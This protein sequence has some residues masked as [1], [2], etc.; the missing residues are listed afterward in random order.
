MLFG[1]TALEVAIGMIFVYLLLSLLCSAVAEYIE[2]WRGVRGKN[3]RKGIEMLLND[4][5]PKG[6]KLAAGKDLAARLYSHGLI[7]PLYRERGKLPSYIPSRTF[8][9]A[10]WDM[11]FP[12][13]QR[14]E[15]AGGQRA[16]SGR[17]DHRVPLSERPVN[18]C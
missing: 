9:L 2:A 14:A 12:A 15:A 6:E 7:R 10:L 13:E 16:G 18:L 1:S 17:R 4:L 3:L 8:A 5:D 11:A